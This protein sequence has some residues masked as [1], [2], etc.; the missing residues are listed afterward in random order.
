MAIIE[1]RVTEA[2]GQ[3]GIQHELSFDMIGGYKGPQNM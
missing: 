2:Y 3:E 1:V